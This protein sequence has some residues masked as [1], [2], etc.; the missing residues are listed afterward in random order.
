MWAA[1]EMRQEKQLTWAGFPLPP[2]AGTSSERQIIKMFVR[3]CLMA[4][5]AQNN[6]RRFCGKLSWHVRRHFIITKNTITQP[7]KCN[8]L[9]TVHI[10]LLYLNLSEIL[11]LIYPSLST[12]FGPESK[13]VLTFRAREGLHSEILTLML[14]PQIPPDSINISGIFYFHL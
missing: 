12:F 13:S 5:A 1:C 3:E 10:N 14:L 7:K 11:S 8:V 6:A 2:R 4:K 9:L